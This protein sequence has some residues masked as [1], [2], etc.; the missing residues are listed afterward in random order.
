MGNEVDLILVVDVAPFRMAID[1]IGIDSYADHPTYGVTELFEFV[2]FGEFA[3]GFLPAGEVSEGG[4]EFGSCGV[5]RR[6]VQ[7]NVA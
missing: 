4:L 2:G 1:F 7:Y 6:V 3:V 5:W